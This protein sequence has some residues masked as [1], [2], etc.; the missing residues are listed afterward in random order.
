MPTTTVRVGEGKL[1]ARGQVGHSRPSLSSRCL[2][3]MV[4]LPRRSPRRLRSEST[5]FGETRKT[6][7]GAPQNHPFQVS[8]RWA[9]KAKRRH[10]VWRRHGLA[11]NFKPARLPMAIIPR[12][13]VPVADRDRIWVYHRPPVIISRGPGII[14]RGCGGVNHRLRA[15]HRLRSLGIHHRGCGSVSHGRRSIIHGGGRRGG[16]VQRIQQDRTGNHPG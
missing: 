9:D 12:P 16:A 7:V 13:P 8:K 3:F 1:A 14:D 10:R 4:F 11:W 5:S 15:N 6:Q 2:N